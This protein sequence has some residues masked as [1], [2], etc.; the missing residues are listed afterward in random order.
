MIVANLKFK[1]RFKA[2]GGGRVPVR[3]SAVNYVQNI[4]AR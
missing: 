3:P 4:P 2:I 1:F